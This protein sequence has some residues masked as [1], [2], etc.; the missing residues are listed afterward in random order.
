MLKMKLELEEKTKSVALLQK[1]LVSYKTVFDF[2]MLLHDYKYSDFNAGDLKY[3][4]K[5]FAREN[6]FS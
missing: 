3:R 6:C 2:F 1:A 4:L 5:Q